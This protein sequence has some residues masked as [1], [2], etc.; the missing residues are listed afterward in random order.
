[1]NFILY[2]FMLST[3]IIKQHTSKLSMK[4]KKESWTQCHRICIAS[5]CFLLS[6]LI[7]C[8]HWM[9]TINF[10]MNWHFYFFYLYFELIKIGTICRNIYFSNQPS[11][12]SHWCLITILTLSLFNIHK[13]LNKIVVIVVVFFNKMLISLSKSLDTCLIIACM[14]ITS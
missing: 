10:N 12:S 1:M 5:F 3:M 4:N 13:C 14:L 6:W 9:N 8:E 7:D 11:L 2:L